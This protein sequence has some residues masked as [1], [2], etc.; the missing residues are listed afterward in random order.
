MK[1][2]YGEIIDSATSKINQILFKIL[3]SIVIAQRAFYFYYIFL[4]AFVVNLSIEK[5]L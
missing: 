3:Q 2:N 5:D 1:N 4:V